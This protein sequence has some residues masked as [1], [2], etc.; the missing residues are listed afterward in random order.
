MHLKV[1]K[2]LE[3]KQREILKKIIQYGF[4]FG[5]VNLASFIFA[6]L[7]GRFGDKIGAK[8][9]YNI[10]GMMQGASALAFGFLSFV[11]NVSVFLA[12]SYTIR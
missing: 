5:I 11:D 4:V 6:P 2:S 7:F 9:M 8:L 10:A 3:K 1:K 12:L